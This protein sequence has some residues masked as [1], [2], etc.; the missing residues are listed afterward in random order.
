MR[1]MLAIERWFPFYNIMQTG[2]NDGMQTLEQ[3]LFAAVAGGRI[4]PEEALEACEHPDDLLRMLRHR[5]LM[6]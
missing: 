3:A 1:E 6:P 2:S 4:A 5:G